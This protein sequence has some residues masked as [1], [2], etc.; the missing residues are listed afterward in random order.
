MNLEFFSPA[1]FQ[2][3]VPPCEISSMDP[4]F[5][6]RLDEARCLAGIPFVLTSALRSVAHER[7]MGRPGTSSHTLGVAVDISCRDS[8]SRLR[9]VSALLD[10]GFRRIGIADTF[11]HVD[12]DPDKAHCLWLY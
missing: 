3:C 4:S 9:I 12:A 5:L 1:D 11:I 7:K 2:K 10:A 6:V 8:V